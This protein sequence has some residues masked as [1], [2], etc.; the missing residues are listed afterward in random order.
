MSV[1]R[2]VLAP[3]RNRLTAWVGLALSSLTFSACADATD[4]ELLEI[5]GAG[6]VFG[7]VFLDADASGDFTTGDTPIGDADV[8][9]VTAASAVTVSVAN[10]DDFGRFTLVDVP[11]GSYTLSISS[12]VTGDSLEVVGSGTLLSI[13]RGDTT[14]VDL[15]VSYPVLP[16]GDVQVATVGQRVFTSGIA[17][18]PRLNFDPTGQVHFTDGATYLRAMAVERA[19]IAAGDSVLILG[20]VSSDNGRTILQ[21]VTP[22][23]LIPQA[24]AVMPLEVTADEA[25]TA[26]GGGLDA[27]LV[28]VREL[29]ITDTTTA[30]DGHFRFWAV[31]GADSVEVVLRS[32]LGF[33][34]SAVRPDTVVRISQAVG[35]LSP[36]DDAGTVRWRLLP[37]SAQDV[38]LETRLADISMAASFDTTEASFGDTVQV[39]VVVS[40]AGPLAATALEVRDT[41]P[42]GVDFLSSSTTRGTYDSGTGL[43]PVGDLAVGAADTLVIRMEVTNPGPG[44]VRNT[45]QS[46]GSLLEVDPIAGNN[47]AVIF[48]NILPPIPPPA[49]PS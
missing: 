23:R 18:N 35:L 1:T 9:L 34:N 24:Q 42:S 22:L 10:T 12:V 4:V 39:T 38:V 45:A 31:D 44:T 14:T 13:D 3:G 40:N 11:V 33:N 2:S 20:R 28:R 30:V 7:V 47:G 36:F 25:A 48:L 27:A 37:R 43:W 16:F 5:E 46:L 6:V 49:P 17:L 19:N 41:I 32:F 26:D 15:G 29:E 21:D 8:L